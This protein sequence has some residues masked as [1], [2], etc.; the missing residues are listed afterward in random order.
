MV[1]AMLE[2]CLGGSKKL[3]GREASLGMKPYAGQCL[4]NTFMGNW[5][6]LTS[7]GECKGNKTIGQSGCSWKTVTRDKTI[8]ADCLRNQ[9]FVQACLNDQTMPLYNAK[10]TM[11]KAFKQC[12]DIPHTFGQEYMKMKKNVVDQDQVQWEMLRSGQM[13]GLFNYY[14]P[15]F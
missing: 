3:V 6:S 13:S 14:Y 12:P 7:A 5:Y 4:N 10:A 2:F 15:E 9:G 8:S 11:E 1:S